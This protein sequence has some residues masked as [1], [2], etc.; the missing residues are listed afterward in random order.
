MNP[1]RCRVALRPRGP[2]ES[3]DLALVLLWL[4]PRAFLRLARFWVGLPC[5]AALAC[6]A[7]SPDGLPG[8]LPVLLLWPALPIPFLLLAAAALFHDDLPAGLWRR[9]VPLRT[10]AAC[11]GLE[12][13]RAALLCLGPLGLLGAAPLTWTAEC[14][15]LERCRVGRA[16]VRSTQLAAAA[17]VDALAHAALA[18][19]A[20]ATWGALVAE[21][22]AWVLWSLL[23]GPGPPP[24]AGSFGTPYAVIGL[25]ATAPLVGAWRL[26]LYVDARTRAEAWDLQ[27]DLRAAGL[28]R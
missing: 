12:V 18:F 7:A 8:A 11:V 16:L 2:L 13:V 20:V 22:G 19:L 6:A 14:L 26:L 15:L 4:R 9:G 3:L 1:D 28:H 10:L 27:V 17:P 21:V 5:A 25:L 24:L 23:G